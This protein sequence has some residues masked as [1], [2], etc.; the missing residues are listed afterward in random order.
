MA[1]LKTIKSALISVFYKDGLEPIVR[2]LHEENVTIYST[3]GSKSFIEALNIPVKSVEGLTGFPE[4]LGGRVKTLHPKIFGGI[5]NRRANTTD[6][7]EINK[8][9]IPEIDLVIVDLYPFEET[10][11]S[12]AS[13]EDIIEKIDIG[14][15]A[16]IRAAAK[17]YNDVVIIPSV[18]RYTDLLNCLEENKCASSLAQ[19]QYFAM[20]AFAVS[21][22]YDS[23]IFQYFSSQDNDV[24]LLRISENQSHSLRYGENPHQKGAFFGDLNA[25]FEQLHGKE[26]SYNNLLDL[27]A[28]INLIR[29]FGTTTPTFGIL[30]HNNA[31]GFASRATLK[32]AYQAALTADPVSAFGG[33]LV[34]NTKMDTETATLVNDLFC[35]VVIAPAFDEAALTI[36]KSKK[37][38]V[39]L[40]DKGLKLPNKNYRSALNGLLVQDKDNKVET[41]EDLKTVTHI[42][43]KAEHIDDLL[44]ANKLVK[45]TKSNT[46]ILVKNQ[47]LLASGTGQTSRVDALNQAIHKAK[48]FNFDLNDAVM[49]SDAFFPFPDC[50]EI[51]NNEGIKTVIQPGGSIKDE[52]SIAYCN[53]NNMAMVFTGIRHFKH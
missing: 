53:A 44:F 35:E 30:K 46:I 9:E 24:D 4:I 43:P 49:A 11:S 31:C 22:N 28:A 12:G 5:L 20:H 41:A 27:D 26:L 18:E 45:H 25:F 1:E 3:G 8:F 14:G 19:R 48:S 38:R 40:I 33:I 37:N 7:R 51:A 29:D 2:K 32:E 10:V 39:L 42:E 50:V 21:S 47:Q 36:L 34:S 13:N 23:K 16:L 52:L 15:I 17:N 6:Q